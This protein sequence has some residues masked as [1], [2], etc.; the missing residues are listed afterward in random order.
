ANASAQ[1]TVTGTV[2]S[3]EDGEP[4]PGVNVVVENTTKG[5][6]TGIDGT[7]SIELGPDETSLNFT[8]VGYTTQTVAVNGRTTVNV[9]M[10]PDTKTLEEVVVIGYGIVRKSDL[11]GSVSSVKGE[12]LTR[13]PAVSPM[14]N[15]QGKV[16]GLQVTSPSGA[17]G[18]SPVVRIRG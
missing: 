12:D 15:L 16:S 11:T 4:L 7:Y 13:I 18:S 5:T 1:T 9:V 17:P 2:T 14:Q 3:S 10:E 6:V 8:F